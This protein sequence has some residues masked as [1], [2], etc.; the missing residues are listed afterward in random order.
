METKT[1]RVEQSPR[2]RN[3]D[4]HARA[5]WFSEMKQSH[6]IIFF[7]ICLILGILVFATAVHVIETTPARARLVHAAAPVETV[8]AKKQNLDEVIGG[9]GS[10][11]QG[12]TVQLTS[13]VT[14]DALEVP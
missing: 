11:E 13:Q 14:A 10:V 2:G 6:W 4:P 5:S 8:T 9:S 12:Q 7:A 1:Q 3:S